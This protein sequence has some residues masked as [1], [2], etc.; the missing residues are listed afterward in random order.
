MDKV[1]YLRDGVEIVRDGEVF[2]SMR[3]V[4]GGVEIECTNEECSRDGVSVEVE[5]ADRLVDT[6]KCSEC[7]KGMYVEGE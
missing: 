6:P 4:S 5:E 1:R 7:G 2:C 3:R